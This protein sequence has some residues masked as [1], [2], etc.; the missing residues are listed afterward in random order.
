MLELFLVLY[1][2]TT[3]FLLFILSCVSAYAVECSAI[4]P[5][6][7]TFTTNSVDS[8]ESGVTCNGASCSP[9]PFTSSSYS[10]SSSGNFNQSTIVG[11]TIYAKNSWNTSEGASVNFTGSGTAIIYIK[12]NATI[13]KN[14]DIN[15]GGDPAN[16]LLIFNKTLK[17]EEGAEINAFIYVNGSETNIEKNSTINGGIAAQTKLI[18]KENSTFTYTASDANNIDASSFCSVSTPVSPI[19]NYRFDECSYS[20]AA[21]ETID[22]TGNYSATS[23]GAMQSTDSG[24]V[25]RA[26]NLSNY[27]Q[28]FQTSIPLAGSFTISTWFKKPTSTSDSSHFVLGAM[29]SGGDLLYLDRDNGWRWGIYNGVSSISGTYSFASLDSNWHHMAIVYNGGISYLVIDGVWVDTINTAPSGTLKYIGTSYNFVGTS[30]AQ[31]FRAPLDEFMVMNSALSLAQI[32]EIYNNQASNKNFDGSS[33]AAVT[34]NIVPIVNYRFD[35]CEYTGAAFEVIDQTGSYSATSYGTMQS[36]DNGV[37]ERAAELSDYSQHFQTSIPLAASFT[38]STWFKKPTSTSDSSHFVIG[39]MQ[40]GG[41]LLYLDRDNGWRWGIYNG[42]S[43]ISGTYSFASLDSN[44]HHLA[45]V[46]NGGISYLVIDGVW[47]DTINTAPSGT[48][49]Y[50]GTSYNFVGTSSAQGF[51]APLD[52]FMVMNSALSL[53]QIQEMYTNQASNKNFDGNSRAAVICNDIDHYQIIHDGNGLTCDAETVTIKACINSFDGSC[54]LSSDSTSLNLVATGASNTVTKATSFTGSTTVDFNYTVNE[55]IALSIAGESVS[56]SNGTVCND[57]SSGS[58]NMTFANAGFIFSGINTIEV[59]SVANSDVTIQA[60]KDVDGVCTGVFSGAQNVE[61]AI[62]TISPSSI[63][64]DVYSIGS[65]DVDLNLAG[66]VS[67]YKTISLNFDVDS[68]ATLASNTYFDAGDI[69]LHAKHTIAA[70]PDNPAVTLLG[71][72]SFYVRPFAFKLSPTNSADAPLIETIAAGAITQKAG[73]DFTLLIE[74]VN[75]QGNKTVNF[76]SKQ[77]ELSLQRLLPNAGGVNGN[78]TYASGETITS[79]D[80]AN[81]YL[82]GELLSFTNGQYQYS[83]AKYSEVGT[84]RMA[85]R[86]VQTAENIGDYAE[87]SNSLGRFT[88][89]YFQQ[90]IETGDVGSI[91]ANH[92]ATCSAQPWVYS[93]QTT[94]GSGTIRYGG[95][96]PVLTITSYNND[97]GITENYIGDFVKLENDDVTFDS[98]TTTHTNTLPLTG[99]VSADGTMTNLG[100]GVVEYQL[101]DQHHFTYTRNNTSLIAPFD[102]E[103]ELPIVS[104]IDGDGIELRPSIVGTDYFVNPSFTSGVNVRFGRWVIENSYGPETDDLPQQMY[105]QQYNGTGFVTNVDDSCSAISTQNSEVTLTD[106]TLTAAT[107]GV[108]VITDA[109]LLGASRVITLDKP[110]PIARGTVN[111]EYEVPTWL[112]FDWE[113]SDGNNDGPYLDN[114]SAVATFGLF[115]GND[116]IISWREVSK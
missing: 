2:L 92:N 66:S 34:C 45:I 24:V 96:T 107:T 111:I 29:Q 97:G 5:G 27:G 94:D 15:K 44:W 37:V 115:R 101:S 35:Q 69:T 63:S 56:A 105:V 70:T 52:E 57:N 32:Q 100:S 91:V 42:V 43:S 67:N 99:D 19:A 47:V 48:L 11:G 23:Y 87:G 95:L 73:A 38:I 54:T 51:R 16:V 88:P 28:H 65:D 4:F 71:S 104:I 30:S 18:L 49:K 17:I 46:Y 7:Q 108:N 68:K 76:T 114:P 62:E 10:Y 106:G 21:F 93:G 102:A 13:R 64:G 61:F 98:P 36:T 81:D 14:V 39:A 80:T 82:A 78:L 113:N 9:G 60:V 112:K 84:L 79:S 86:E 31:G 12:N 8:I 41:D 3:A 109:F 89:A 110:D 72:S 53:A 20:G 75:E 58:C 6:L 26:A 40:S 116:R 59:A 83:Q 33:R 77:V 74:A 22:Q 90:I 25:E 85:V 1:R 50:I 55:T 103:F